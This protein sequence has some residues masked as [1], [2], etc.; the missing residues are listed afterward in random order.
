[1]RRSKIDH[2]TR[3]FRSA[4]ARLRTLVEEII[5]GDDGPPSSPA[6][7]TTD[8]RH[9]SPFWVSEVGGQWARPW[10]REPVR[11]DR[12]STR[13]NS[14]HVA[15]SYAVFYLNKKKKD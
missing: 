3:L 14:S 8:H 11:T 12:K 2:Y 4:L 13:L 5:P 7:L 15:I 6:P 1:M 9:A 10:A